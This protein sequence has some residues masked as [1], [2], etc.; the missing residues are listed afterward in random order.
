MTLS[1][2]GGVALHVLG[3]FIAKQGGNKGQINQNDNI[4]HASGKFLD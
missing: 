4:L 2:T 1:I 3:L